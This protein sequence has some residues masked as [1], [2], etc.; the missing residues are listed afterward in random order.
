VKYTPAGG[1]IQVTLRAMASERGDVVEL[2]FSDTGQGIP[3]EDLSK[4]FEPFYTTK[5]QDGNGLGLAVIWGIIDNHNGTINV[6]SEVGKGSTFII[7][8]PL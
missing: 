8:L 5:G 3:K 6:E 2:C 1:R 4:I 7:H